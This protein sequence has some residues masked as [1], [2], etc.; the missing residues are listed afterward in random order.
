MKIQQFLYIV[1][2]AYYMLKNRWIVNFHKFLSI[3]LS[4]NLYIR[5]IA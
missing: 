3:F 4:K 2:L 5:F 1:I